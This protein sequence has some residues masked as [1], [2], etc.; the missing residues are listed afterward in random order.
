VITVHVPWINSDGTMHVR[1][2]PH[3]THTHPIACTHCARIDALRCNTCCAGLC[4]QCALHTSSVMMQHQCC[5][6]SAS[7]DHV[8]DLR[9]IRSRSRYQQLSVSRILSQCDHRIV[10]A[11]TFGANLY[12][13]AK[14]AAKKAT[15]KAAPKKKAAAKKVAKKKK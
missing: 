4:T 11:H 2:P 10:H 14:K 15:K 5:G 13:M 8:E 1:L 6:G 7:N 9:S 12:T 3:C